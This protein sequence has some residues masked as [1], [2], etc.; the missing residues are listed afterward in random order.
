[1]AEVKTNPDIGVGF[2]F[3]HYSKGNLGKN[4]TGKA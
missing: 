2:I 4:C 3:G 1:M